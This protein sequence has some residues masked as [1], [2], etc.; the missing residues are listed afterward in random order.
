[1]HASKKANQRGDDLEKRLR[2][3]ESVGVG[4][5]KDDGSKL[6]R[7]KELYDKKLQQQRQESQ[8]ELKAA[9][10][11]QESEFLLKQKQQENASNTNSLQQPSYL[12]EQLKHCRSEHEA[13]KAELA[14]ALEKIAL[15]EYECEG[16][17][18]SFQEK[19]RTEVTSRSLL[20][21]ECEQSLLQAQKE[22]REAQEE[23]SFLNQ[24]LVALESEL[25]MQQKSS[26]QL[27][28]ALDVRTQEVED[29]QERLLEEEQKKERL[30]GEVHSAATRDVTMEYRKLINEEKD[31]WQLPLQKK[32]AQAQ[33]E[34]DRRLK[35][36]VAE[37]D[38]QRVDDKKR[39]DD[40]YE[41]LDKQWANKLNQEKRSA[42]QNANKLREQLLQSQ[43]VLS[44]VEATLASEQQNK[45]QQLERASMELQTAR[46]QVKDLQHQLQELS[47]SEDQLQ[48]QLQ[49]QSNQL[50]AAMQDKRNMQEQLEEEQ[51]EFDKCLRIKAMNIQR[52]QQA[53]H[54]IQ[55][56]FATEFHSLEQQL[57]SKQL[58]ND[59]L[60]E[61]LDQVNAKLESQQGLV[62]QA[63]QIQEQENSKDLHEA[64]ENAIVETEAYWKQE[65]DVVKRTERNLHEKKL[66]NL[67]IQNEKKL[68]ALRKENQQKL[69]EETQRYWSISSVQLP[70]HCGPAD[71]RR[72]LRGLS[73]YVL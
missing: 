54:V 1:M 19:L 8:R 43:Q 13:T 53:T 33:K 52:Q 3:S 44:E 50:Q 27:H 28:V 70:S 34:S 16:Q 66:K 67:E 23:V 32:L 62:L 30:A 63:A 7:L 49:K 20:E 69:Q 68:S 60:Q 4:H 21:R 2:D 25:E 17:V 36:K 73:V 61:E 38:K 39:T 59:I 24:R 14:A 45:A 5:S 57:Q 64:M 11:Q 42:A 31:S 51:A 10:R 15:V 46:A 22:Q 37:M 48:A 58:D 29:M 71:L 55:Q 18:R 26:E 40:R 65:L 6:D 56:S 41:R 12:S 35:D 47:S 9:L 72:N